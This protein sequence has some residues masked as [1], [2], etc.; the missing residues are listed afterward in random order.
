[1]RSVFPLFCL[2]KIFT[3][4]SLYPLASLSSTSR[5]SASSPS[6]CVASPTSSPSYI[7][8]PLLRLGP[9][10]SAS[11]APTPPMRSAS[12]AL[13]SPSRSASSCLHAR[14]AVP[15]SWQCPR[16]IC[17]SVLTISTPGIF[18][19]RADTCVCGVTATHDALCSHTHLF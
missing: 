16:S 11:V 12:V 1:M 15:R 17:V 9:S 18:S 19:P 14:A 13:T 6:S 10:R 8:S 2:G 5:S 4:P 7:T 3:N